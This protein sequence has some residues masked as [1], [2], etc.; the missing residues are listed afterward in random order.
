[1]TKHPHH[2]RWCYL[3]L[4]ILQSLSP[5][6]EGI[7]G[8]ETV[9]ANLPL[10]RWLQHWGWQDVFCPDLPLSHQLPL[11]HA[12]VSQHEEEVVAATDVGMGARPP[13]QRRSVQVAPSQLQRGALGEDT[14][15]MTEVHQVISIVWDTSRRNIWAGVMRHDT[16][17]PLTCLH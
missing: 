1:M 5:F 15:M 4:V 9:W 17:Q 13:L 10:Q 14:F 7:W 12:Q 11:Q 16:V 6:S 8:L 3:E 2:G